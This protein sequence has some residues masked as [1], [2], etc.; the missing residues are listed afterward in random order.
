[1]SE[2]VPPVL[3]AVG[4][5]SKSALPSSSIPEVIVE[6]HVK[7]HLPRDISMK[8]MDSQDIMTTY[9]TG[10]VGQ[11]VP[12]VCG[13]VRPWFAGLEEHLPDVLVQGAKKLPQ[14]LV[15]GRVILPQITASV[16]T[17]KDQADQHHLNHV[18]KPD[19]LVLH[20]VDARLDH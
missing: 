18:N 14:G 15:L 20:T 17:R 8:H 7:K 13:R 2:E 10:G 1:M 3:P 19:G 5:D 12:A 11:L 9:R 16:L 6:K 4:P